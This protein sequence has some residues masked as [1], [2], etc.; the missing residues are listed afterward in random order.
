[1]NRVTSPS[2][3]SPEPRA[4]GETS[5]CV[6]T[7]PMTTNEN[8]QIFGF[9][10]TDETQQASVF[11]QYRK[12]QTKTK[13]YVVCTN[14]RQTCEELISARQCPALKLHINLY[15]YIYMRIDT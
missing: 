3:S 2:S 4:L 10:Y 9:V 6:Y 7:P 11:I 12:P 13:K 14:G 1:M 5:I 15:I 8:Q